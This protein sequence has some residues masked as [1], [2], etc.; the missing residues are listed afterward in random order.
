MGRKRGALMTTFDFM[1]QSIW[2]VDKEG[3]RVALS[4]QEALDLLQWLSDKRAALLSASHPGAKPGQEREKRL[5]IRLRQVLLD[6]LD[7]LKAAI[8]QAR[9]S[10]LTFKVLDVPIDLVTERALQLLKEFQVEY[11]IHPLLEE[12]DAFAQG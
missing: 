12:H 7:E 6:H 1:D 2:I 4:P 9:E 8:P 10:V 11:M 5:E 3:H